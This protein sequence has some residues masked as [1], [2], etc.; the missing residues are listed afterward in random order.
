[1][2]PNQPLQPGN[3]GP[4]PEVDELDPTEVTPDAHY[5]KYKDMSYKDLAVR[6]MELKKEAAEATATATALTAEFD[7]IRLRVVPERFEK[8]DM[9]SM[10]IQGVGRLGI[11]TDAYCNIIPGLTEDLINWMKKHPDYQYLIKEGINSSTLK[12]VV[13][14]MAEQDATTDQEVDLAAE[15]DDSVEKPK[16]EF[17]QIQQFVKFTP[18]KRASVTRG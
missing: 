16:T 3:S 15:F 8:D 10:R 17:E 13:K 4:A 18:F 2:K 9:T 6:M 7:V 1:M 14:A 12:S 5:A 11:A